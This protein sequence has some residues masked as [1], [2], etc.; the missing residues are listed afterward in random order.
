M[1]IKHFYQHVSKYIHLDQ[2]VCKTY[3]ILDN[4]P[5][6]LVD[7]AQPI[8]NRKHIMTAKWRYKKRQIQKYMSLLRAQHIITLS[9]K[10]K[11][12]MV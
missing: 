5:A 2:G 8:P 11:N 4:V 10:R 3:T 6:L 9:K 1:S 12:G 7:N